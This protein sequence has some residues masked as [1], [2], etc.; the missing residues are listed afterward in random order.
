MC[1]GLHRR[2]GA[3]AEMSIVNV[4]MGTPHCMRL[5][6]TTISAARGSVLSQVQMQIS[7]FRGENFAVNIYL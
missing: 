3:G 2:K 4:P 1:A 5:A 7:Q 6:S